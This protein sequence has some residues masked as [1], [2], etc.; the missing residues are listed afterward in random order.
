M[1]RKFIV[2]TTINGPTEA[3][4]RF[5]ALADWTLIVV[6]DHKT[7]PDYH[8]ESGI[9]L[10]PDDQE[11]LAPEL[12]RLIGW[13]CIQRRNLGFVLALDEGADI[14]ATVDD[15][16]IPYDHWGT[17]LLVGNTVPIRTYLTGD[18]CFDPIGVTEHAHLWHRGFPLQLL[19]GRDYTQYEIRE[20]RVDVQ[21]DFWDGDPDID[22]VCRMEHAPDIAFDERSFPFAADATSPFNSQNTFLTA[23]ALRR[24]FM[25]PF[26]G[27]M[28][29]IWAAYHLQSLGY[30]VA[31]AR[32][33][34][35][36]E[37]NPQDLTRNMVDEF[38]GYERNAEMV[39]A[40]GAGTYDFRDFW[41]EQACQAYD[42]YLRRVDA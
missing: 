20:I 32:S 5:D 31:Y 27:R 1:N 19:A 30:R 41:P 23:D 36:Q 3:I 34:V 17:G 12:S 24:Y 29:D 39:A 38:I 35:R 40:I 4:R 16:N 33:S 28:D 42:A 13:N 21:A 14:V 8:L 22:A 11:K 7:P 18:G 10:S 15:D 25:V 6:G 9:Y 2:S 37:R 26:V